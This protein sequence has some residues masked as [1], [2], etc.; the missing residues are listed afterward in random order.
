MHCLAQGWHHRQVHSG[1]GHKALP[2][3]GQL[4]VESSR[5]AI[6]NFLI[7]LEHGVPIFLLFWALQLHVRFCQ[8]LF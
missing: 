8:N 1:Q 7:S 5:I 2:Q 4:L 3:K 6:L